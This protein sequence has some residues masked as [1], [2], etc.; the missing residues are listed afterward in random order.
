MIAST[1][2]PYKFSA[3]VLQ[4]LGAEQLSSDDFQNLAAL[5]TLTGIASPAQLRALQEKPER[6]TQVISREN[7]AAYALEALGIPT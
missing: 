3:S 6:F 4:A 7:A 5:E 1:A 2:N